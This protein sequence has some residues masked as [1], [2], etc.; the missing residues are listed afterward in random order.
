MT[1]LTP[2]RL[3]QLVLTALERTAFVLAEPITAEQAAEHPAP[4]H[5]SR[6]SYHGPSDGEIVLAASEGFI[7][8]LA[9]SLLGVEAADVNPA[10]EGQDA[11]KELANIVGGSVILELG[12]EDCM[13]SLKLPRLTSPAEL[14]SPIPAQSVCHLDSVGELLEVRWY[15]TPMAQAAAA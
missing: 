1:A 5:F 7:L 9:S 4:T 14:A 15:P 8:E 10:V 6:I 12:G 13:Y 11:I 3:A 2:D